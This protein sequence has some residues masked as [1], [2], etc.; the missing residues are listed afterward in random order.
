M[1]M[2]RTMVMK[3]R[4]KNQMK[5]TINLKIKGNRKMKNEHFDE[6]KEEQ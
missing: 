4:K 5:M 2:T 1:K 3:N 6:V